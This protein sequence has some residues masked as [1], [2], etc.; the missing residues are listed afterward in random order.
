MT[1]QDYVEAVV[2]AQGGDVGAFEDVVRTFQD[3][4]VGYAV[5]I[6]RDFHLAEDV[7]QESFVHSYLNL[8][9]L[10]DPAAFPGW[11]KRIVLKFC[12]RAVRREPVWE[13][14]SQVNLPA[15]GAPIDETIE[16]AE[17]HRLIWDAIWQLEREDREVI[18]MFHL[19]GL[20]QAIVASFL[21][22]SRRDNK[23]S[24]AQS[25]EGSARKDDKNGR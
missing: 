12:D 18:V 19:S 3:V 9:Q 2:R 13:D 11:L 4:A 5:A 21:G 8:S 6:L 20:S 16:R 17:Q 15:S 7:S 24:T 22:V 14:V 25:K 23:K 10:H 1:S